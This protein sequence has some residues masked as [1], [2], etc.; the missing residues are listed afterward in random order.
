M[1]NKFRESAFKVRRLAGAISKLGPGPGK[2]QEATVENETANVEKKVRS[3]KNVANEIRLKQKIMSAFADEIKPQLNLSGFRTEGERA[4]DK[5]KEITVED[6]K[7]NIL[8][9]LPEMNDDE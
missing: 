3:F 5:E 8:K 2:K 6:E 7:K 4:A 1:N 9:D